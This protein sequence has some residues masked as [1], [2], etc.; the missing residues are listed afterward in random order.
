MNCP[1]RLPVRFSGR[2]GLLILTFCASLSFA[3]GKPEPR[4]PL[5]EPAEETLEKSPRPD[6][7]NRLDLNRAQEKRID[8]ILRGLYRD[9]A[10]YDRARHPLLDEVIAQVEAGE[11][12]RDKLLPLAARAVVEFE[13]AYPKLLDAM[14][15]LHVLLTVKQRKQLMDLVSG[16]EKQEL[17]PEERRAAREERLG[18]LLDLST[19]QKAR[20]YPAFAMLAIKN[21]GLLNHFLD[22]IE[23]GKEAFVSDTFDAHELSLAKELRLMEVAEVFYEALHTSLPA[24]SPEQRKTL[25][26]LLEARYR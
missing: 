14:N 25:G 5:E 4:V 6:L 13:L 16:E 20:L 26:A 17:S 3:C 22:G 23:E 1:P 19:G 2:G 8:A 10:E 18:R 21:W 7:L 15:E 9:F 24:L 11:L 12:D